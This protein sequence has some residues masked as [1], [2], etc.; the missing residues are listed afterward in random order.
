V[1]DELAAA[2]SRVDAL[3]E[4]AEP[5]PPVTKRGECLDEVAE[6]PAEAVELPDDN[7]VLL[8]GEGQSLLQADPFGTDTAGGV[9]EDPLAPGLGQGVVLEVELLISG[10]T[11]A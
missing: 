8:A 11:R 6:R 2:G 4:A 10:E 7:G 9:G 1:E 3:L 5:D